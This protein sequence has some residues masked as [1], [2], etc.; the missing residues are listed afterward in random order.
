MLKNIYII[1]VIIATLIIFTKFD[2]NYNLPNIYYSFA[3][4]ICG[5]SPLIVYI[6]KRS[7]QNNKNK[8]D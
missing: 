6:I 3:Y 2:D 7:R 5:T 1:L 4:I 8:L